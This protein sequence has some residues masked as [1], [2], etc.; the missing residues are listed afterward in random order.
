MPLPKISLPIYELTLPSNNKK[1]KYRPFT[2]K[3]EKILLTAQ[4][5]KEVD[6]IIIAIKQIVNN[7]LIDYDIEKLALF[8]IEYILLTL[9]SK[10]VDNIV[11]FKVTDPD[12]KSEVELQLDLSNIKIEK[13][14]DHSNKIKVSDEYTLFMR[15]PS[16]DEF[17]TMIKEGAQSSE[18][19]YEIMIACMDQ[20]VS[21]QEV[22][23]FED[24]T[25]EEVDNFIDSLETNVTKE[26]KKFFESI[27]KIRFEIP[28]TNSKGEKKTFVIQGTQSFFI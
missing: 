5:S 26:M 7:C 19:N 17:S 10:S 24:F 11:N 8:D 22:H 25:K 23:K 15:Y 3:E 9:R 14:K 2:V 20:L 13:A 21:E 28:Y 18:K 1:I 4:E 27:P 12:T 6:Q 16:I